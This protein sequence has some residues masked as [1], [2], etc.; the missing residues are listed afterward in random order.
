M[1]IVGWSGLAVVPHWNGKRFIVE[2]GLWPDRW[3]I[4]NWYMFKMSHLPF[5][6]ASCGLRTCTYWGSVFCWIQW[7][8]DLPNEEKAS[9]AAPPLRTA[10]QRQWFISVVIWA[11]DRKRVSSCVGLMFWV[12]SG[13]LSGIRWRCPSKVYNN[14]V[15]S[16]HVLF[17]HLMGSVHLSTIHL[18]GAKLSWLP[19][20][21]GCSIGHESRLLHVSTEQNKKSKYRSNS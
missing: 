3:F 6:F 16:L 7:S 10:K 21:V 9:Q 11:E 18:N 17:I 5:S 8:A 13:L 1:L 19:L 4:I 14:P 12:H 15:V 20:V 2:V